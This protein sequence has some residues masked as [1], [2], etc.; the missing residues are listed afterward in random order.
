METHPFLIPLPIMFCLN[1]QMEEKTFR[2]NLVRLPLLALLVIYCHVAFRLALVYLGISLP[3]QHEV[4][5][6]SEVLTS[7]V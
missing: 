5:N 6:E 4:H 3:G 2:F 1:K 7:C